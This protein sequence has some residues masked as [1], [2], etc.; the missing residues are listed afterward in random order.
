MMPKTGEMCHT[1]TP[2]PMLLGKSGKCG[3]QVMHGQE[4]CW[5]RDGRW[6]DKPKEG[7]KA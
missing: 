6:E 4:A 3:H 5:R 7:A 1:P 2:C